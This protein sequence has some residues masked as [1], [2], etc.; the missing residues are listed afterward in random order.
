MQS[1]RHH[2][3]LRITIGKFAAIHDDVEA[4]S[5]DTEGKLA[6]VHS[7]PARPQTFSTNVSRNGWINEIFVG[8]SRNSSKIMNFDHVRAQVLD[9]LSCWFQ[10][11]CCTRYSAVRL[12]L[13]VDFERLGAE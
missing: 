10:K 6:N 3:E 4:L 2:F 8:G 5:N 12:F 1:K 7:M 11:R 13:K 9:L